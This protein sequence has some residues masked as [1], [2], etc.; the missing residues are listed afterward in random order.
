MVMSSGKIKEIKMAPC[1]VW[2][3]GFETPLEFY[4][5]CIHNAYL[6]QYYFKMSFCGKHIQYKPVTESVGHHQ[7]PLA[8]GS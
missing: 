8:E 2:L 3:L 7:F 6:Q 4:N 1:I 5:S